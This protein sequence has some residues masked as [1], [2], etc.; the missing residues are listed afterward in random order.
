M[1]GVDA[2]FCVVCMLLLSVV[3]EKMQPFKNQERI[4][5]KAVMILKIECKV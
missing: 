2:D 5:E 4:S 3:F 1:D